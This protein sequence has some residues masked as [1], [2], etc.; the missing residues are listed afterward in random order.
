MISRV[1]IAPG[2]NKEST[3]NMS[4][5]WID[6]NNV[7][8]RSGQPESIGGWVDTHSLDLIG[9]GREVFRWFANDGSI[10]KFVGTHWKAYIVKGETA[11]DITPIR[12]EVNPATSVSMTSVSGSKIYTIDDTGHGAVRNDYVTF[13]LIDNASAWG[14]S[15]AQL[16]KEHKITKIN[17]TDQ[18]EIFID[19]TAGSSV[20]PTAFTEVGDSNIKYQINVGFNVFAA[21]AGWGISSWGTGLWG[22]PSVLASTELSQTLRLWSVENRG[23]DLLFSPRGGGIYYWSKT[24]HANTTT[25]VPD[26]RAQDF[27]DFT[28]EFATGFQ[29]SSVPTNNN[30]VFLSGKDGHLVSLGCTEFG[31]TNSITKTLV[32]WSDN[33]LNA[34]EIFDWYPRPS[35]TAGGQILL[36]GSDIIGYVNTRS[37]TLI[38][39]DIAIHS[40]Q[41]VGPPDTFAFDVVAKHTTLKSPRAMVQAGNQVFFMG[42]NAFYVYGGS[43]V[44]IPCSVKEYVFTDINNVQAYKIFTTFDPAFSEIRWFYPSENSLD[45]DKYVSFNYLENIWSIGNMDMIATPLTPVS[46]SNTNS[47]TSWQNNDSRFGPL[48]TYT[49]TFDNSS[50]PESYTSSLYNHEIGRSAHLENL[51]TFV[52]SG[53]IEIGD[54]D[55][56]MYVSKQIPDITYLDSVPSSA[57]MLLT[58]WGKK[59]P[60]STTQ[61]SVT[62]AL[63]STTEKLNMKARAREIRIRYTSETDDYG[64]RA[65]DLRVDMKPDGRS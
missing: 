5:S 6:G 41:W 37:E 46:I 38:W 19:V 9:V 65:G 17:D 44:Q 14:L 62:A 26:R 27:D 55:S 40:M 30:L 32:R 52:E 3:A 2:I 34:N 15:S 11:T 47:I 29:P 58:I 49:K 56:L 33:D 64:W 54:G 36:E 4:D 43:V 57:S 42:K 25:G 31:S 45:I 21:G 50:T 35:N 59:Y 7:R 51:S 12:R 13:E 1:Q 63:L 61:T 20:G 10:Y 16:N 60:Q 18:Y 48:S 8:F 28:T 22:Y 23:E 24:H 53:S 39:T